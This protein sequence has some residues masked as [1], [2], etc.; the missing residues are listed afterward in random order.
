MANKF[1][2]ISK[3]YFNQYRNYDFTLADWVL[4]LTEFTERLQGNVG[5]KIYLEEVIEVGTIVNEEQATEQEFIA[6][7]DTIRGTFF[8]Y[9]D[10]G[11]YVGAAIQIE[12]DNQIVSATVERITNGGS[13]LVID[14]AASTTINASKWGKDTIR[15]DVVI[16]VTTRPD[17]L[18]YKYGLNPNSRTFPSYLSPLDGCEQSY[19]L[20]GITGSY[21]QMRFTGKEQG[22]DLGVV[23][24]KFDTTRAS[25]LHQ[26]TLTHEFIIPFY[27]EGELSNIQ[28]EINPTYLKRNDSIKYGNGFFFGGAKNDTVLSYEDLGDIGNVGYFNDNFNGFENF[29]AIEDYTVTNA[30]NT[31]KIE[32]TET[33]TVTFSITSSSAIGFSGGEDII[34]Y[35]SKLPNSQEYTNQ[36]EPFEDVWV[37]DEVKQTEGSPAAGSLKSFSNFTVTLNAGKLDVSVDV[38]FTPDDQDRF[39]EGDADLLYFTIATQNL[40]SPDTVDRTNVI[41][42]GDDVT[43]NTEQKG[44]ISGWQ[45]NIYKHS[46]FDS[47]VG[48]TDLNGWDGD[49]NGQD[50]TFTLDISGDSVISSAKFLV[51]ADD[52]TDF[53]I[54]S[55]QN[56][57]YTIQTTTNTSNQQFQVLNV[58][59]Q[60]NLTL[61]STELLNRVKFDSIVPGAPSTTQTFNGSIGFQVP[62]RDWV[63]NLNVPISFYDNSE[64]NNNRNEKTSNYDDGTYDIKTCL[65]LVVSTPVD[66]EAP[67]GANFLTTYNLLSDGSVISDFD[68]NGG[69]FVGSVKLYDLTGTK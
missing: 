41:V 13:D 51:V 9:S 62:W 14:S 21:Q 19:Q 18:L 48:Y 55:S 44:L 64:P 29:Y 11:I 46:E 33:N 43:K 68:T 57:P 38:S 37:F 45:P 69:T 49:L 40:S 59:I 5:E 60:N 53:F 25:Y 1:T 24:V 20:Q 7:T 10:E 65:Q 52:G 39:S 58:D 56:I 15:K 50:W 2:V 4:N 31:G 67:L 47:G 30:S 42:R 26:F 63:E 17:F 36:K 16:K 54:L 3:K 23:E 8:D 27:T 35:N 34:L 66:T 61:P 32:I 6:L 22:S 12:F 28:N